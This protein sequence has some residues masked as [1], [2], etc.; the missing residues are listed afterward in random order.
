MKVEQITVF[1][2]NQSY[3]LGK[4]KTAFVGTLADWHSRFY[5]NPDLLPDNIRKEE[6]HPET[7]PVQDPSQE[8]ILATEYG[9]WEKT[10]QQLKKYVITVDEVVDIIQQPNAL[11]SRPTS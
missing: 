11:S 8:V 10:P 5:Q 7:L 1:L 2:E 3:F 6:F 9:T 4:K